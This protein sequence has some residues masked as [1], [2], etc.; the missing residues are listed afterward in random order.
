[1]IASIV[2]LDV[3]RQEFV[4]DVD[5]LA[6]PRHHVFRHVFES[7]D[8]PDF[9]DATETKGPP[10]QARWIF[11]Y[12]SEKRMLH[13]IH[14]RYIDVMLALQNYQY[15]W[16]TALERERRAD[17]ERREALF[18][19]GATKQAQFGNRSPNELLK[20]GPGAY[21]TSDRKGM[22]IWVGKNP[23]TQRQQLQWYPMSGY[24]AFDKDIA[25]FLERGCSINEALKLQ[26][27][28]FDR[29]F[30]DS[31]H[32][33]RIPVEPGTRAELSHGQWHR[34][35]VKRGRGD[36]WRREGNLRSDRDRLAAHTRSSPRHAS[37]RKGQFA[38]S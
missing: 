12:S 27:R 31:A 35:K 2:A 37:C 30:R 22:W 19:Y 33:C 16:K 5:P 38:T 11:K 25:W 10:G 17:A 36:C 14:S 9:V 29:S 3:A 8:C 24:G 1:M 34:E 23:G 18:K 4:I 26:T 21:K 15:G 13:A 32:G 20:M 28:Q 6:T 7:G